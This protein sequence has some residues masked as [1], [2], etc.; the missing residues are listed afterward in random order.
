MTK[1]EKTALESYKR[2]NKARK[3]QLLARMGFKNQEAYFTSLGIASK[4]KAP[5]KKS[6]S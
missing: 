5:A 1:A 2:S 4:T 6:S 3:A